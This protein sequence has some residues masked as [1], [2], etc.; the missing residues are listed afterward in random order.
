[1]LMNWSESQLEWLRDTFRDFIRD[2][3]WDA[4]DERKAKAVLRNLNIALDVP[5]PR[6]PAA[7]PPAPVHELRAQYERDRARRT[8]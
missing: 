3:V 1:M 5:A 7:D 8:S 2:G 4:D 6:L